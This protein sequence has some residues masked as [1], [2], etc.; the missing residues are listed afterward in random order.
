MDVADTDKDIK[1]VTKEFENVQRALVPSSKSACCTADLA[2]VEKEKVM[3][4]FHRNEIQALVATSLIE[5]GVMLNATVMLVENA[6]HF[7][8]AAG[9]RIAGTHLTRG[10]RKFLHFDFDRRDVRVAGAG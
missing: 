10:A 5:A 2:V 6:E 9:N 3:A 4:A 1:A 8:G 7:A